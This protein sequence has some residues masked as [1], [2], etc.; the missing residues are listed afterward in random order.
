MIVT[1]RCHLLLLISLIAFGNLAALDAQWHNETVQ[2]GDSL[3]AIFQRL[4]LSQL[5]LQQVLDIDDSTVDLNYLYPQ[6]RLMFLISK[7]NSL[8]KFI[9]P[10][11]TDKNLLI[12]RVSPNKFI[13]VVD[14]QPNTP[15]H[16]YA[17]VSGTIKQSLSHDAQAAGLSLAQIL[18]VADIFDFQIDYQRELR[19]GDSFTVVCEYAT[20]SQACG[21]HIVAAQIKTRRKDLQAIRFASTQGKMKY[22]TPS[23]EAL[24]KS[25][26]R[27]PLKSYTR[28]SSAFNPNRRHP[29]LKVVRPH[30]GVDLAAP[31]GTPVY[32]ANDGRIDFSGYKSG[33]GN[34][35]YIQHSSRYSTRYAH[36]DSIQKGLRRHQTI[37][38]GDILGYVG[39]TGTATGPHLHF[40]VRI[41][42]DAYDPLTVKLPSGYAIPT[43]R[44]HEFKQL[45]QEL[46]ALFD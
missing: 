28:V 45:A 31:K 21:G 24:I 6:Q 5:Q 14:D 33:Y 4:N 11:A 42:G 34:V 35:V 2:S 38:K 18:A 32:A 7:N 12:I 17:V 15:Q 19:R 22:F 36:L 40:E 26:D 30:L 37:K 1:L 29:I 46:S 8:E 20:A 25:F 10:L 27:T 43:A 3:S 39:D 13:S 44:Q 9:Y 41:N 23:G 16:H